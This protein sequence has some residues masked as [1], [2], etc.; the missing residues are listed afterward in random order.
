MSF[1]FNYNSLLFFGAD[2]VTFYIITSKFSFS[3]G[4]A[5]PFYARANGLAKIIGQSSGGGECC[6]FGFNFPSGQGLGYS[7][8]YH[9]GY[10]NTNDNKY[11]GDEAGAATTY[12]VDSSWYELFDVDVFG[13]RI[14]LAENN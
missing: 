4:N 14:D 12:S 9:L 1:G 3:C 10:Y 8:P 13:Q 5:F 6:V 11:Y 7:S 2:D